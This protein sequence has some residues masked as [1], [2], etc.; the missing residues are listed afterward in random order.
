[1]IKKELG[2]IINQKEIAADIY[3]LTLE[4]ELVNEIKAPGQFIHIRVSSGQ[5]PLLRRPISIASFD[6]S[7]S[8]LTMI[9]RK[10]GKGTS[11]MAKMTEGMMLDL[12]GPLGNGFPVNEVSAGETALLVGGGIGVPPLYELSSQL[13]ARGVKVIHV[14]GFQ[15]ESA[16][17]YENEFLKNGTTYVTTADGSYGEK[18]FVTDVIKNLPF[19]CLYTC[20][21]TPMLK[22]IEQ[23]Y[24]DKKVFLS[25]EELMGCGIGACLACVCK[26]ADDPMGVGYKKVC[27]D[28]PVFRAGE[29]LI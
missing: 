27:S 9:Y 8:R 19:D 10:Q 4:A 17:F 1:M 29:V 2:K 12:L 16:V 3:E 25:L 11:L 6:K 15:T 23:E 20:G 21:P 18:G 5:D 26:R 13:K 24:P 28:G 14:L 22:A 7:N